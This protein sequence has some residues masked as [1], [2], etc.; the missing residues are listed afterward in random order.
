MPQLWDSSVTHM[1]YRPSSESHQPPPPQLEVCSDPSLLYPHSHSV[2]CTSSVSQDLPDQPESQA[3]APESVEQIP[4][5]EQSKSSEHPIGM[6][7]RAAQARRN[8]GAQR[9]TNQTVNIPTR[10]LAVPKRRMA[11]GSR[12][13]FFG[14]NS[15]AIL[16]I[17]DI[18]EL[19][20][21]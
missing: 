6:T 12:H 1:K 2:G 17:K 20:F 9:A 21:R 15:K 5:K 11:P 3:Q 16:I 14:C 18:L 13:K 19:R 8:E 10:R 7:F 4:F